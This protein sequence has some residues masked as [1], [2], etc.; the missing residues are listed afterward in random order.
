M[1][2]GVNTVFTFSRPLLILDKEIKSDNGYM[3]VY[4]YRLPVVFA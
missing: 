4:H 2:N 1:R 3:N